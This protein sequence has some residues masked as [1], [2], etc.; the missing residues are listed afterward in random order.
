M[1]REFLK[2]TA[3]RW[4]P[5]FL[6][7]VFCVEMFIPASAAVGA[8]A[9][10]SS[11]EMESFFDTVISQQLSV[12]NI[13]GATVAVV[14][15]DELAFAKGYGY[16]D[17]DSQVP[18]QADKT[19]FFIGSDGKLFTWTAV[20]Q[21]VGQGKLDLH[22]DINQYLDFTIPAAFGEPITLHHLMTHTAGFEEDFN[23]LLLDD[24]QK[25]L[26][27]REHLLRFLPDRVY[28][29]GKVSAYSNYGTALAGYIVEQV[30]GQSFEAYLAENILQPLGMDHSFVGNSL[31]TEFAADLSKGY[32]YENG[33][34][35]PL[36]FE[37]TAAV[38]CAPVRTT[39]TD[40]SR[41]MVAHLND[42]CIDGVCILPADMVELM[43][44]PQFSH[45]PQMSGMA[46]GFLDIEI[47]GQRILW[48]MGES[49]RFTTML[50]LIPEQD[51]GLVVSY[52]TP[53][54]DGRDILFR[55][56]DTFFP[57]DRPPLEPVPLTN[58]VERAAIFNGTYVPARSAHTSLQILVRYT[59]AVPVVI[60]QGKLSFAGW[61]FVETEPGLFHQ[62]DGDRV[63]AFTQDA[64]E[65]NWLFLGP[66]AYF[67]V[68]WY[69]T[70]A[71]LFALLGGILLVFLSVWISRLVTVFRRKSQNA[72]GQL[73]WRLAAWLGLFD[74]GLLTG[75]VSVLL[76]LADRYVYHSETVMVI[77]VLYW[78]AVPW[79]LAALGFAWRAWL[80]G[81]W[82][83]SR[84]IHYTLVALAAAAFIWL[85]YYLMRFGSWI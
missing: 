80:R 32:K 76:A 35:V 51:L 10:I 50:A 69:E 70:P 48:H 78:L 47:N 33:S 64:D 8:P 37:W 49:A 1:I 17:L 84:R 21:L 59:S 42:G 56:M 79:T 29:P 77:S 81:E 9:G 30:S 45:H 3:S 12:E 46:Y 54:A 20:M 75:L 67:Q 7:V 58:W 66:L 72:H 65:K 18:V 57:V 13:A 22:A 39:V 38:P 16:A 68:P 85:G 73:A 40:L 63:L 43:H 4:L 82:N 61:D 14:Q 31:P 55:F 25:I 83:L 71:F 24:P 23:S 5:T 26:P 36:D 62:V 53:P 60:D 74:F 41:F 11:T 44:S 2:W 27:L 6:L 28:P 19:L 52:N 15:N 34:Y